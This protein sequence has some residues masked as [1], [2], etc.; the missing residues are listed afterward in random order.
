MIDHSLAIGEYLPGSSFMHRLDARTKIVLFF[1]LLYCAF[2]SNN[3]T[4][5]FF[6]MVFI[7]TLATLTSVPISVWTK[8]LMR[9][10]PMLVITFAL[11][12]FFTEPGFYY[13]FGG[14]I[15]PIGKNSLVHSVI[16]TFQLVSAILLALILSFSTPPSAVTFAIEWFTSP[17]ALLKISTTEFSLTVFLAMRFVPVFQQ[18][19]QK[20]RDAQIS[21]G[22]DFQAGSILKKGK[23]LL[24]IFHPAFISTIRRSEL[25]AQAMSAR[26]FMPGRKRSHFSR[27]SI[28]KEDI[29]AIMVVLLYLLFITAQDYLIV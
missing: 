15:L 29:V 17:L 8:C 2:S 7:M 13:E 16:L 10:S 5:A 3:S 11:N 1:I 20:I 27:N 24:G 25:L 28:S 22:I 26:G 12:L 19:L 9:F 23:R 21:R 4:M 6:S 14:V 18:E